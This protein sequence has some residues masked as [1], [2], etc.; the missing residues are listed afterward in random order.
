METVLYTVQSGDTLYK[1]AQRFDTTVNMIARYNGIV[2]PDYIEAGRILRIPVSEIPA[3]Q[4]AK[5][6]PYRE[7]I[8]KKGDT[9]AAIASKCGVGLQRIAAFNGILDPDVIQ[10]GQ[11]L[12][13]PFPLPK[14][15]EQET[16]IQKGDTLDA[17]AKQ[18]GV[19]A[20]QIAQRN[21]IA[22]ADRI[23]A[24]ESILLPAGRQNPGRC[25]R[26]GTGNPLYLPE[27]ALR[28]GKRHGSAGIRTHRGGGNLYP[29][30]APQGKRLPA[31]F[32][33]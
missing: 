28:P 24:G 14:D 29:G 21:N 10:E 4:K 17:I 8:V 16:V 30:S 23:T 2:D 9:L 25:L 27:R 5:A 11:V 32:L 33:G 22:D 18:A 3:M 13:I 6:M 12:R 1:I 19:T 7:Y 15:G 20:Q 26:N 31:P